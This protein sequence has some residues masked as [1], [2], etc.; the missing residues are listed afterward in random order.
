MWTLKC[1]LYMIL[2]DLP[3]MFFSF[4]MI[5]QYIWEHWKHTAAFKKTNSLH[6]QN[7]FLYSRI[8]L[9][10]DLCHTGTIRSG[11][12]S[13]TSLLIDLLCS[14]KNHTIIKKYECKLHS[15]ACKSGSLHFI[16]VQCIIYFN[17]QSNT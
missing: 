4:P 6:S 10:S 13:I 15:E 14:K 12:D 17:K 7:S 2:F 8:T 16:N 1:M 11:D 5:K 9:Q 3:Q